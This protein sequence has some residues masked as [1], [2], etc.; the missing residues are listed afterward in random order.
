MLL[1][2]TILLI[3]LLLLLYN[4]NS[5]S[6]C[7]NND[8]LP[9]SFRVNGNDINGHI[10][11]V[12]LVNDYQVPALLNFI[13][14]T[15]TLQYL[16]SHRL[17][18]HFICNGMRSKYFIEKILQHDCI[19]IDN[20]IRYKHEYQKIIYKLIDIMEENIDYATII[21]DLDTIWIRNM[22]AFYDYL[23]TKHDIISIS[24]SNN[25]YSKY[26]SSSYSGI[27]FK[28]TLSI[29]KLAKIIV[30]NI[31][32][33]QYDNKDILNELFYT[34]NKICYNTT[35]NS[36][37]S[38]SNSSFDIFTG[39]Q[40]NFNC[41]DN[42]A[43]SYIY[44]PK[45]MTPSNEKDIKCNLSNVLFYHQKLEKCD[46]IDY[47]TINCSFTTS[48]EWII[49]DHFSHLMFSQK[50]NII[51][52]IKF[53]NKISTS[54]NVFDS[55]VQKHLIQ[56]IQTFVDK[57]KVINFCEKYSMICKRKIF[58]EKMHDQPFDAIE[59]FD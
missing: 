18:F 11:L 39:V 10:H 43:G 4:C 28:N 25:Q 24:Q 52:H 1:L 47:L 32:S 29:K 58:A 55:G 50:S 40:G 36:L 14:M 12:L 33:G 7:S 41:I 59:V 15:I 20:Q 34:S 3:V 31:E 44:L 56:I 42:V 6:I 38:A 45:Y 35:Q 27:F 22:I 2:S 49:K 23:G 54:D 13:A 30:N 46:N 21:F 26:I 9:S 5:E 16:P 48:T 37:S 8:I 51:P 53:H 19:K 57:E 17:M